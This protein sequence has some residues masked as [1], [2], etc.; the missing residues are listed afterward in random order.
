MFLIE[1]FE[2]LIVIAKIEGNFIKSVDKIG[3]Q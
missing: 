2:D 1:D 3:T